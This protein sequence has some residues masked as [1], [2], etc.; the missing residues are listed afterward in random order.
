[1]YRPIV[2]LQAIGVNRAMPHMLVVNNSLVPSMNLNS[3]FNVRSGTYLRTFTNNGTDRLSTV[4][5][6]AIKRRKKIDVE[7]G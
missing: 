7:P 1:M 6:H 3:V 5:K 2:V 4:L